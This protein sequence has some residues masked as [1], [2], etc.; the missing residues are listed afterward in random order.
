MLALPL[1]SVWMVRPLPISTVAFGMYRIATRIAA[2]L[3]WLQASAASSA[4]SGY[5]ALW[6]PGFVDLVPQKTNLV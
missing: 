3:D 1:V 5:V 6:Q 2:P 4:E